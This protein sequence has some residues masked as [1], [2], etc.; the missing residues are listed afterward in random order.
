MPD[1]ADA[2]VVWL[3]AGPELEGP[4]LEGPELEAGPE[5][6]A[7][8]PKRKLAN[9]QNACRTGRGDAKIARKRRRKGTE[10][11]TSMDAPEAAGPELE[12]AGPEA[13]G[14]ELEAGPELVVGGALP[15]MG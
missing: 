13:A 7:A 15:A 8:G 3:A 6:E 9:G 11:E 4:E 1:E 10:D 5:W 2:L 14:P 12:A